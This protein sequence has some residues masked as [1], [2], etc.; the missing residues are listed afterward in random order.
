MDIELPLLLIAVLSS[1]LLAVRALR[2]KPIAVDWAIVSAVVLAVSAVGFSYFE[3]YV[4]VVSFG[5]WFLLAWAPALLTR[6][7]LY[8]NYHQWGGLASTLAWGTYAL[9]PTRP[10]WIQASRLRVIGL[11]QAGKPAEAIAVLDKMIEKAP[12]AKRLEMLW[13]QLM[14]M[15]LAE[16]WDALDATLEAMPEEALAQPGVLPLILRFDVEL[17]RRSRGFG[18]YFRHAR[19]FESDAMASLRDAIS[20]GLF[21]FAGRREDVELL[22]GGQLRSA[23]AHMRE[24]WGVTA[25]FVAGVP[26]AEAKLQALAASNEHAVAR[27]ARIRLLFKER[28]VNDP[29][30][31]EWE[32]RLDHLSRSLELERRYR[33]G[34][35][36]ASIPVVTYVTG[37]LLVAIFG[38][39]VLLGGSTNEEVLARMGAHHTPSIVHGE[40]YRLVAFLFLHYGA[41]HLIFNLL[42]LLILAPFV[43]RALGRAR[44]TILYLLS[45]LAG[46][47]IALVRD[48]MTNSENMLIGASGCVMGVVG[49]SCAVLLR[50]YRR[51]R[52]LLGKRRLMILAVVVLL[53][54]ALDFFIPN[55]S[56]IGHT[57]GVVV[58]FLLGLVIAHPGLD[59]PVP[60]LPIRAAPEPIERIA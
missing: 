55:I 9:H 31:V 32:T 54:T 3:A 33:Y 4:G 51:D 39:E 49:A 13:E 38:V 6:A 58:G 48:V 21:A 40:V 35:S 46:G 29:L 53:Q 14:R 24:L 22:F 47:I 17:G 10:Y 37:A 16:D 5:L 52:T 12:P 18:R 57:A 50:G 45:G 41:A 30:R 26:G 1:I 2:A 15:R 43:E 25:D 8:A 34:S 20:L 23:G 60:P 36:S 27:A 11:E 59:R 28:L 42:G 7:A 56:Q 19:L 44:F